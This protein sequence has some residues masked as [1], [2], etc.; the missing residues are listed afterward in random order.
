MDYDAFEST[1]TACVYAKNVNVT[2]PKQQMIATWATSINE[3]VKQA[4]L[5]KCVAS[6]HVTLQSATSWRTG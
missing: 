4:A 3:Q 1:A 2:L 5:L 6:C